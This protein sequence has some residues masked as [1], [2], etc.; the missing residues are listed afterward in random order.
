MYCNNCGEKLKKDAKFCPKCGHNVDYSSRMN[1]RNNS[2]INP[3]TNLKS[4]KGD[5]WGSDSKSKKGNIELHSTDLWNSDSKQNKIPLKSPYMATQNSNSSKEDMHNVNYA[6]SKQKNIP[7]SVS[8]QN[9]ISSTSNKDYN[10]LKNV[11]NN[12]DGEMDYG[13]AKVILALIVCCCIGLFIFGNIG[14]LLVPDQN[15]EN[16]S[17]SVSLG[18]IVADDIDDS[19]NDYSELST[20]RLGSKE[21]PKKS[22]DYIYGDEGDINPNYGDYYYI[23]GALWRDDNK[24]IGG[25]GTFT[26]ISGKNPYASSSSKYHSSGS[27]SSS[28]SSSS[29]S[30]FTTSYDNKYHKYFASKKSNKFHETYCS[31]GSKIKNSNR[32]YYNSRREALNDGKKPCKHCQP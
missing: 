6:K 19:S 3:K 22:R 4:P 30:S 16:L 11:G 15:T 20:P 1:S 24:Y 8:K 14:S 2:E 31:Q 21:N 23:D 5:L 13:P 12:S 10:N 25:A 28:S 9:Y 29:S 7:D 17:S 26:F 32:I 27:G 18:N